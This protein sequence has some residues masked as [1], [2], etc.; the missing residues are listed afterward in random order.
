[1]PNKHYLEEE[2]EDLIRTDPAIWN[3]IRRSSLDGVWYWDLEKPEQEWM[4]PEFWQLF[5][6]DPATKKHLASEW[7]DLIDPDDLKVAIGNF[8]RHLED[9]AYPYDQIVRY[10][11]ADGGDVWVRCR[12]LAIRDATGKPIRLLGAHNDFT[13]LMSTQIDLTRANSLLNLVLETVT[14]GI[15]GLD[16]HGKVVII[17]QAGRNILGIED[18]KT[19]FAWPEAIGFHDPIDAQ[20]LPA[21]QYPVPLA[22]SEG[23][24][25]A[26]IYLINVPT[27]GGFRYVR[28]ISSRVAASDTPV[29]AV[30]VLEDVTTQEISRQ[31][32]ERSNRLDALGQLTG[33]IAHDFNNLLATIQYAVQLTGQQDIPDQ[34]RAFL[35][36]AL[37]SIERGV[38]LTQR[39][40]AFGRS[41]PGLS[42]SHS[43]AKIMLEFEQLVR[44]A[45]EEDISLE[46]ELPEED[47]WVYCDSGQLE[48]A[49]LNLVLNARDAIA[50]EQGKKGRR[51]VIGTREVAEI[52]ADYQMRK[53]HSNSYVATGM[54]EEHAFDQSRNDAKAYR[55]TEFYVADEGPGMSAE[56]RRRAIDPFFS[57]KSQNAG[58]GLGLSMVYGF[59]QQANGEMRIYSKEGVGTTIRLLLPR[60]TAEGDREQ[61][62][63]RN[64][65]PR[66]KG[67]RILIVEDEASLLAMLKEILASLDYTV[68]GAKSG[69]QALAML[70]ELDAVDLV[71]TDVVMPE[72]MSGFELADEVH[73]RYPD[74]SILYMSGYTGFTESQ[75]GDVIAPI[76][77]KPVTPQDLAV[78]IADILKANAVR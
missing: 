23:P 37:S 15:V 45:I 32:I 20:P 29:R 34:A 30:L 38:S 24:R 57:T 77:S 78:A 63:E 35:N 3:F 8:E 21:D 41:Q 13:D 17:N 66:G 52:E 36:T 54:R 46:F 61:P 73:Q 58:S 75:M 70:E 74:I 4:S 39:L 47:F 1:M 49:L 55:Y 26:R 9:P 28:I 76:L 71:L 68:H 67:Q 7:Q 65:P 50:M 6:I 59:I 25:V 40:L 18:L 42:K 62:A 44:P 27:S 64:V 16:D 72:D 22:L 2:L 5:G 53:E 69:K 56:V 48:N 10:R 14:S 60:G 51:I 19:P 31:Q 12:G 11:H 33:G 43:A